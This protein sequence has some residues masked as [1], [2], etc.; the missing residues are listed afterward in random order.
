MNQVFAIAA[1]APSRF[2]NFV[3]AGETSALLGLAAPMVCVALVNMG[4]SITDTVMMGWI[5]PTALAAGAVVSDLYSIVYYFMAG[6]LSAVSPLIAH[7]MGAGNMG[8]VSR[9]MRRGFVAALFLVVPASVSVWYA[10]DLLGLFGVEERVIT[11]GREYARMMALTIVPMMFVAVWRNAFAALSRPRVFLIATLAA[12]PVNA[13]ANYVLMFGLGEIPAMGLAGAGLASAL[14]A[15]GLVAGF[16]VYSFLNREMRDLRLFR[17]WRLVD[18]AGLQEIFRLGIPIGFYSIGEVGV[19]LLSTVIISLFGTEALAAHAITL[20]MAGVVYAAALGLSQAATVRVGYAVGRD[21]N[22]QV[23]EAVW[24]SMA[25]GVV[26]GVAIFIGLSAT[27]A[28]LPWMFLDAAS[29]AAGDVAVHA[30]DLLLLLGILSLGQSPRAMA[31]A[32]LRGFKDTRV[33]MV[34]C[35]SG[36]WA[37]GMPVS[38]GAAF[39]LGYGADGVWAGLAVGVMASALLMCGRLWQR[40]DGAW[41]S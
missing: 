9:I 28:A 39:F 5:S 8:N 38:Y 16:S 12:L 41:R 27:A 13:L 22:L 36:N 33:P 20:R 21:D 26:S 32:V 29:A 3:S 10:S 4:M 25:A 18:R 7:A 17:H 6:I 34:L 2:R 14:V 23:R 40:N 19:F 1:G 15:F 31:S 24:T 35:L 30:R 37:I 11:L